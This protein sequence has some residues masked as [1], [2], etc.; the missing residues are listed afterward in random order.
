MFTRVMSAKGG[1]LCKRVLITTT[2]EIMIRM[3]RIENKSFCIN[4]IPG[5]MA[6]TE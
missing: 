4:W 2:L 6:I 1:G 5:R 3:D